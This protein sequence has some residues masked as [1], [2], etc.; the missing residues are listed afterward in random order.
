MD[1]LINKIRTNALRKKRRNKPVRST[2]YVEKKAPRTKSVDLK[3]KDVIKGGNGKMTV[4]GTQD[5]LQENTQGKNI[6]QSVI[7]LPTYPVPSEDLVITPVEP[8]VPQTLDNA[9]ITPVSTLVETPVVN[10]KIVSS[11]EPLEETE[12]ETDAFLAQIDEFRARAKQ[13][14]EVILSRESRAQELQKIVD[15][16]SGQVEVLQSVIDERQKVAEEVTGVVLNKIETLDDQ[17]NEKLTQLDVSFSEN[18]ASVHKSNQYVVS[19][20]KA[21][22]E[23]LSETVKLMQEDIAGKVHAESVQSYRNTQDVLKKIEEKVDGVEAVN[24]KVKSVRGYVKFIVAMIVL[25]FLGII[26]MLLS[27]F[28]VFDLIL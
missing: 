5:N 23:Q 7:E 24:K 19:Q 26:A 14:H 21:E 28:G 17:I 27:S 8:S 20:L 6:A 16:R 15:E 4:K 22:F 9:E 3:N 10:Q 1:S 12:P 11:N 13:L 18:L 2:Y 25:N